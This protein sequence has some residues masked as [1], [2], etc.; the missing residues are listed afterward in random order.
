MDKSGTR[1]AGTSRARPR[2]RLRNPE[3]GAPWIA[4]VAD[5]ESQP[6]HCPEEASGRSLLDCI[7][8]HGIGPVGHSKANP[9]HVRDLP[10]K[11]RNRK[12]TVAAALTCPQIPQ[13]GL[14]HFARRKPPPSRPR[15][16]LPRPE[17]R[18]LPIPPAPTRRRAHPRIRF[19]TRAHRPVGWIAHFLPS[20][21]A[22][23]ALFGLPRRRQMS[24]PS[25]RL[26]E[27][28]DAP[29]TVDADNAVTRRR[30]D[31]YYR[32]PR[33]ASPDILPDA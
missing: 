9:D 5:G 23:A 16:F 22:F 1:P 32:D 25:A 24:R 19:R 33:R 21:G 26:H 2:Q 11:N 14:A 4:I 17:R 6:R 30:I 8:D 12:P 31:L 20:S 29:S 28:D 7:I 3:S 27:E 13:E 10:A 18:F 15:C